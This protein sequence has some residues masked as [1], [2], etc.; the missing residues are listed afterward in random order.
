MKKNSLRRREKKQR[1]ERQA[2]QLARKRELPIIE[3]IFDVEKP[4]CPY[5]GSTEMIQIG[6]AW[7]EGVEWE[8]IKCGKCREGFQILWDGNGTKVPL[9]QSSG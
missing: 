6:G 9:G 4:V 2:R 3:M 7:F 1:A 5:C 8:D